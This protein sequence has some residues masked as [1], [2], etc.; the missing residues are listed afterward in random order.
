[1]VRLQA[2]LIALTLAACGA[3]EPSP[4]PADATP[5][6]RPLVPSGWVTI[7]SND[8]DTELTVPPDLGRFELDTP[9]GV[10][11]QAEF[12]GQVTPL[13]IWAHGPND[14]P[15][16]PA[17]GE[18]LRSWL[19]RGTWF[20]EE[21]RGGISLIGDVSEREVLLPAGRALE[22]A[23]T[24]QPGT[25]EESRVVAYAIE[26]TGGFAVLQILGEPDAL[27][28]RADELRLITLLVRFGS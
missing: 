26:T 23:A 12:D 9:A 21:G 28:A 19:E 15:D 10:F 17:A 11:L 18:S 20:P 14:L 8:R 7:A 1:M 27:E 22:L 24:V 2:V 5:P 25:V 4:P 16:Q 13:Q 6:D 3:T